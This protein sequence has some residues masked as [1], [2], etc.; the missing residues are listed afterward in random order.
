MIKAIETK[1]RGYRFRS[2]LEARWA[3]FFDAL[4][5]EWEYE[6]EGYDLGTEGFYL[7]DFI[8][9]DALWIEVK[10]TH[11]T[12][13]EIAKIEKLAKETDKNAFIQYGNINACGKGKTA[14]LMGV[15]VF[16]NG[17][18]VTV[19]NCVWCVCPS[20][21]ALQISP[22]GSVFWPAFVHNRNCDLKNAI[23][24]IP[25]EGILAYFKD[26]GISKDELHE[27]T[28]RNPTLINAFK[29]AMSARFEHGEHP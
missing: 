20:C 1:Y 13:T 23:D 11:P 3:V 27:R 22:S 24:T 7:P 28:T 5:I 2:R 10:G 16:D 26:R 18:S 17:E 9:Y 15:W 29:K 19:D 14:E 12:E 21:G 4:G 8:L 6:K 25:E